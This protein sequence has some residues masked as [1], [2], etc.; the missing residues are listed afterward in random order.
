MDKKYREQAQD[1]IQHGE[2]V[3]DDNRP[4]AIKYYIK[5]I[6]FYSQIVEKSTED[7]LKLSKAYYFLATAYFN[8]KQ[9]ELAVP[10][11]S[12]S[13]NQLMQTKLN[14][15]TYRELIEL[16]IDLADTY[17][18]L[19]NQHAVNVVITNAKNAFKLIQV[20]TDKEQALGDPDVNFL[21]FH[22]F[23][24]QKV[25]LGH[26]LK[27]AKFQNNQQLMIKKKEEEDEMSSLFAGF[28]SI[29]VTEKKQ[30]DDELTLMFNGLAIQQ[31]AFTPVPVKDQMP[32]DNDHRNLAM[33]F[34]AMARSYIDKNALKHAINTYEQAIN[35]LGSIK[36][37]SK[38]DAQILQNL[39]RHNNALNSSS[40]KAEASPN[41]AIAAPALQQSNSSVCVSL[42]SF[43]APSERMEDTEDTAA[44]T[45]MQ[46]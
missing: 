12:N 11:Y 30:V 9:Y 6:E 25:S 31:Q 3:I 36:S 43:F 37:P 42:S 46:Q 24:E 4:L 39:Q 38:E 28:K 23:Y 2:D 34:I 13:I 22:M 35:A 5:G 1:S 41:L 21:Q 19:F 45:P 17:G 14:D 27:S 33:Q 16:Y 26:Y 20:K 8:T 29:S 44:H 18:E 15:A 7:H 40:G 32:N 10:S